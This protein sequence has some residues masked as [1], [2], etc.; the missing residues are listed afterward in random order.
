MSHDWAV[1]GRGDDLVTPKQVENVV[2]QKPFVPFRL[3]LKSGE[4]IMVRRPRKSFVSGDEVALVGE[5]RENGSRAAVERLRIIPIEKLA[6]A[7][8]VRDSKRTR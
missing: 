7:E 6:V 3:V 5:C 2:H 1:A 8:N 4:E